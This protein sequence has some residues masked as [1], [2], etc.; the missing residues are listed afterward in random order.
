MCF[1]EIFV[2]ISTALEKIRD[3]S[4]P[5]AP[6]LKMSVSVQEHH[7]ARRTGVQNHASLWTHCIL[8]CLSWRETYLQQEKVICGSVCRT[9]VPV[10]DT[11]LSGANMQELIKVHGPSSLDLPRQA[12]HPGAAVH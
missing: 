11:L 1:L 6:P 2:T 12:A 10:Y 9:T 5:L 4:A 8:I 7:G 3:A